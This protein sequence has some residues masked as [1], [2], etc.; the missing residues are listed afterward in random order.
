MPKKQRVPYQREFVAN[1]Q[2]RQIKDEAKLA[3]PVQRPNPTPFYKTY[4]IDIA[5]SIFRK[6]I[7]HLTRLLVEDVID[8]EVSF[9]FDIEKPIYDQVYESTT[10]QMVKDII[11]ETFAE[12]QREIDQQQ[13]TEVKHIAKEKVVNNLMLD[14]MLGAIAQQGRAMAGGDDVSK[15]LE[16]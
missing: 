12:R 5:E 7:D 8:E 2:I 1:E 15:L 10:T 13:K 9:I 6:E 4:A 11:R 16:G 3:I 14:H